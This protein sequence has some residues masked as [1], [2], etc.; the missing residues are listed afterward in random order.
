[1]NSKNNIFCANYSRSESDDRN[2]NNIDF[3]Q[4]DITSLTPLN[5]DLNL[6]L[7]HIISTSVSAHQFSLDATDGPTRR[8]ASDQSFSQSSVRRPSKRF[9]QIN[10]KTVRSLDFK[11]SQTKKRIFNDNQSMEKKSRQKLRE[12]SSKDST[13]TSAPIVHKKRRLAAN[14]RERK[15]MHSLNIAFDRLRE[16]VP[17]LGGDSKLS[18]Y[19]TLQMAQHYIMALTELLCDRG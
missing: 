1:M 9:R 2:T 5:T 3:S 18:K 17:S 19:E 6:N 4:L 12:S 13:K 15:R 16:V 14:A 11:C 10:S 8:C 7:E